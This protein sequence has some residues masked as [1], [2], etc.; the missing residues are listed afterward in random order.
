M[1][2]DTMGLSSLS[3]GQL[4]LCVH[5]VPLD[6]LDSLSHHSS[7]LVAV[8]MSSPSWLLWDE[9]V[10]CCLVSDMKMFSKGDFLVGSKIALLGVTTKHCTT[11][12][13]IAS[14]IYVVYFPHCAALHVLYCT[15]CCFTELHVAVLHCMLLYCTALHVAELHCIFCTALHVTV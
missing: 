14:H 15:A 9:P 5:F 2:A 13:R 1:P 3:G 6:S 10:S 4:I 12:C 8:R 7:C 11:D